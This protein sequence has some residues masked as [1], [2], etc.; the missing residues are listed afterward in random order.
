LLNKKASTFSNA[1]IALFLVPLLV[2]LLMQVQL[3]MVDDDATPS[4]PPVALVQQE[5]LEEAPLDLN[6]F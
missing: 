2:F 6:V 4:D 5:E 3:V 1:S